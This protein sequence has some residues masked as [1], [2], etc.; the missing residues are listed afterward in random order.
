MDPSS[1]A[2]SSSFSSAAGFVALL[3]F[4]VFVARRRGA[5]VPAAAPAADAFPAAPG[6]APAAR[7]ADLDAPSLPAAPLPDADLDARFDAE[8]FAAPTEAPAEVV[9]APP[10][11]KLLATRRN[12]LVPFR[13]AQAVR[14]AL[15]P[16]A[17]F[18]LGAVVP[19]QVALKFLPAVLRGPVA[20]L[21]HFLTRAPAAAPT[22]PLGLVRVA[23]A[24]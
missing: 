12:A 5:V 3:A 14:K 11:P 4:D 8:F 15:V 23:T 2:C 17:I 22:S 10:P 7:D 20:A 18:L 19:S 13:P 21:L 1:A 16:A 24:L 6:D 9:E